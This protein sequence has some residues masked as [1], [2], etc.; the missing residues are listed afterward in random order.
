MISVTS[1]GIFFQQRS[2]IKPLLIIKGIKNYFNSIII[3]KWH[4][5]IEGIQS[6]IEK[7]KRSYSTHTDVRSLLLLPHWVLYIITINIFSSWS[8][9]I[10]GSLLCAWVMLEINLAG[11]GYLGILRL[12]A[13]IKDAT[14]G[15][16]FILPCYP[17]H[18]WHL[19]LTYSP[20]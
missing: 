5:Y 9:R 19:K 4:W 7:H 15:I 8:N 2:L 20:V 18:V 3:I 14:K 16:L 10:P 11:Q 12:S 6:Y 1:F 13:S 17:W